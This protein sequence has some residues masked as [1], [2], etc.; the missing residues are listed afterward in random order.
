MQCSKE[1]TCLVREF[2]K[3]SLFFFLYFLILIFFFLFFLFLCAPLS[4]FTG[5]HKGPARVTVNTSICPDRHGYGAMRMG[6]QKKGEPR[7]YGVSCGQMMTSP[8][9]LKLRKNV[10]LKPRRAVLFRQPGNT[11]M[12]N[13]IGGSGRFSF[14]FNS[15][16]GDVAEMHQNST[17]S[18]SA[19]DFFLTSFHYISLTFD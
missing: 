7:N 18:V 1:S 6:T 15:P 17:V 4:F 12:V 2:L 9:N 10:Q 19:M 11:M 14:N 5:V 3:Y 16:D 8:A 13:A